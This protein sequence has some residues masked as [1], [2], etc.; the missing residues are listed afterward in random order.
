VIKRNKRPA[1]HFGDRF[2]KLIVLG[3][4]AHKTNAKGHTTYHANVACV[5]G[6]Q[7]SVAIT[8]LKGGNT[9]SCGCANKER[10][11]VSPANY[12]HGMVGT[13]IYK[14]WVAMKGRCNNPNNAGFRHYGGRGI[15]VCE[16]W[17]RFENFY[18][19]MG[20]APE[21]YSIDRIDNNGNY[22]PGNCR[23]ASDLMQAF[24]QTQTIKVIFRGRA[25][26]FN[27]A[28]REIGRN[29]STLREFQLKHGLTHQQTVD[30]YRKLRGS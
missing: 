19:D 14:T 24:N 13:P 12:R 16:R 28:A 26:S 20:D 8:S 1:V 9:N 7:F 6:K 25:V 10:L 21:K 15:T 4:G 29:T 2:G 17:L 23:W 30:Q 5:C 18:A 27:Q 22:E 3:E 11:R